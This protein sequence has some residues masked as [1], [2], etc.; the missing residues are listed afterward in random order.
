MKFTFLNI[1]LG[2]KVDQED[3]HDGSQQSF[4]D[5]FD[6]RMNNDDLM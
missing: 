5:E 4:G 1:V 6:F 3:K 2:E